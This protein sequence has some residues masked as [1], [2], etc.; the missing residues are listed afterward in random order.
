MFVTIKIHEDYSHIM[1]D[2]SV[3]LFLRMNLN[4]SLLNTKPILNKRANVINI[5][6]IA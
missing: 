4:N 3:Q 5:I 6:L 1:E 2:Y